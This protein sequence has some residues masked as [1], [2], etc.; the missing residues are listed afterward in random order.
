MTVTGFT[1]P[2]M[3]HPVRT[4]GQRTFDFSREVVVMAVL[5]R[6]RDSFFDQGAT[7]ELAAA[8]AAAQDA[9]AAGA[10]WLDIGAVPFSP[11]TAQVSEAEEVDR[12]VPVVEAVASTSDIVISVDTYRVEVARR[13]LDAGA[14][15][16]NDTSGLRDPAMA[17]LV[18]SSAATL[19]ITH[20]RARP[21]EHLPRPQYEDVVREVRE[22]LLR[23]VELAVQLGV[24]E[25]RIVLDPGHDLNKN[26]LHSLE[27]TRRL[28]EIAAMGLPLVAAVSNKD[29]IGEATGLAKGERREASLAAATVCMLKGARILR[30][31]DV[32]GSRSAADLVEVLLGLRPP[33]FLRHNLD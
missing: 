19:V 25:E 5:N 21:R 7:Y 22:F 11:D 12:L 14:A 20:S 1:L 6:T 8:L 28:D 13:C 32:R 10:G 23:Q 16:V 9:V 24:P 4:I 27:L 3:R 26:T 29:F 17:E 30:M 31:H 18:A 15:V 33:A 2:A